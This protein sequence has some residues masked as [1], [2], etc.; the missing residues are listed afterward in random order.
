MIYWFTTL[1]IPILNGAY[2]QG[3]GFWEHFLFVLFTPLILVLPLAV[4]QYLRGEY[5]NREQA[6]RLL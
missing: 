1:G 6:S 4:L 3:T 5:T 2:R